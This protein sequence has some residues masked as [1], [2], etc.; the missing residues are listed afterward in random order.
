[1]LQALMKVLVLMLQALKSV[2]EPIPDLACITSTVAK[3]VNTPFIKVSCFKVR[4]LL[5]RAM[6]Q[7]TF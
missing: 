3:E 6:Q 1:M 7:Q 2:L 4:Q 5:Q